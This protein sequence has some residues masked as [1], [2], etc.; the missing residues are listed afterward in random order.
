MSH[1][2]SG[3]LPKL[4]RCLAA[5]AVIEQFRYKWKLQ[6]QLSYCCKLTS[7]HA[8]DALL[9]EIGSGLSA[10]GACPQRFDNNF[11]DTS[12]DGVYPSCLLYMN[13]SRNESAAAP[14]S[15]GNKVMM[16]NSH[17]NR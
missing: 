15:A 3:S 4:H 9:L 17:D 8:R 10:T 6:N 16:G 2:D 7:L 11:H 5:R 1:F 14:D 12:S 13:D